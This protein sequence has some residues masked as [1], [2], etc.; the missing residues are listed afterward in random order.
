[1]NGILEVLTPVLQANLAYQVRPAPLHTPICILDGPGRE[2]YN[3]Q[4][5]I[6]RTVLYAMKSFRKTNVVHAL[7]VLKAY[8]SEVRPYVHISLL[9]YIHICIYIYIYIYIYILS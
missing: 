5:C 9:V 4:L 6:T 7:Y 3:S 2:I 8:M 1:M